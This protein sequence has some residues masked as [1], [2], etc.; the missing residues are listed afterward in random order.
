LP[1]ARENERSFVVLR[2]FS[3]NPCF[4]KLWQVE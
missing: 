4:V 1:V 3:L 2:F